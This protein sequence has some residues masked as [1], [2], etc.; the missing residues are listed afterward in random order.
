MVLI[1]ILFILNML[2]LLMAAVFLYESIRENEPRAPKW[3]LAGLSLHCGLGLAILFVPPAVPWAALVLGGLV[4]TGLILAIP[5]PST[6]CAVNGARG[7]IKGSYQPYD[8]RD[9][10][11]ARNRSLTPGSEPYQDFYRRHPQLEAGDARRRAKGG[12]V[13][14]PGAIDNHYRPNV[15]MA[16]AH[17]LI[18]S[19]LAPHAQAFPP[20][21]VRPAE[22]TP[23]KATSIVKAYARHIGADLVGVCRVDPDWAYSHRGEIFHGDAARWGEEL[24]DPL[25]YAVVIATAMDPDN[26]GTA[27]HTPTS[28]EA[29]LHYAKGAYI[30]TI[31]AQWFAGLGYR[32]T[33]QHHRHYDLLMVP[34]AVDAGLGE[35]GRQGYLIADKYGARV[36]L[37]A[38]MTDMELMP[39]KP[40]DLG[41]E[42]FCE[43]CLKCAESCP[44]KSI[45]LNG[46]QVHRG[47]LRWKLDAE[48]CFDYWA[49]VGTGC[50]ICLAICP[51]SRPNR[52]IHQVVR[53]YLKR[54]P[55]A[56]KVFP[57][58]DNLLYGRRWKPRPA[59][60]WIDYRSN[61][62]RHA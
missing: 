43:A 61:R 23:A 46:Q 9:H 36:R 51:F 40:V 42:T 18:P 59:A 30:T 32:A 50:S 27:P 16:R 13:G 6:A 22:L 19:F 60:H 33:A 62:D 15:A 38:V 3:G 41:A 28:V 7:Y 26:I 17:N 58:I 4:L 20:A 52:P 49:K 25:P 55:L 1:S 56:R 31:L 39:D 54:S 5:G 8:E 34:L 14:K 12:P 10:V 24:P 53:W 21:D 44:S 57:Y 48:S 37:F 35:L 29:G 47:V 11:F 45:P 2:F